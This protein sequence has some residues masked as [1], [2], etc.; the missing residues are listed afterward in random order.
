M[1]SLVLLIPNP[2]PNHEDH[3]EIA[4]GVNRLG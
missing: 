4:K 3:G 1:Q 2:A